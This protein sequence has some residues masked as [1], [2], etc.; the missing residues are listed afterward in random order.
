ME[1]TIILILLVIVM[2]VGSYLSGSIPLVMK[3]SEEKLKFVTVLGAGLLV[4]TALTVI[5]PEGIRSLYMDTQR[6]QTDANT[7]QLSAGLIKP[8]DY[9]RTIGLSLVLGF[10]FMMLV[11][12]VSQ[13]KT[14]K[15]NENDKN[16]TATLGLVV[17]AAADGVALG[18]AATTSHQDVEII[19]F[20]AIMLHKAP[21]AFGLVSFLL[22]E[23]VER[24]QIRKHLGIFSLSAPL[25]TLLTY[26]G[27]GQEQ[28]ETLN[29]VNATGIAMLFSAGTF[30]YVATVHVLPELTQG[31]C[32]HPNRKGGPGKYDYHAIEESREA[33]T[34]DSSANGSAQSYNVQGLR[35][36]ELIIM[37]CGALLPLVITFGH[38]H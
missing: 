9:S 33:A 3:L 38:Q 15:G 2:L 28:R 5:I 10:V 11:D 25:L 18:A 1:E 14:N 4:G 17:H 13:R 23:K 32:S 6:P 19:V 27:I 24:Q 30:L 16:I 20:L 7:S 31:G 35:Y 34:N 12:Q 37:I 22:H 21:A 29:S 36:S 8:H 26:F